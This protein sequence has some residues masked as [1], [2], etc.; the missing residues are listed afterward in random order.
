MIKMK[1]IPSNEQLL[2]IAENIESVMSD[3]KD[4]DMYVIFEVDKEILFKI[5]EDYFYKTNRE[6]NNFTPSDEVE[7]T[8]KGVKFKFIGKN[9]G[10]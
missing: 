4:I 6:S 10:R 2:S 1:N 9:N 5:D 3:V 8:I 7:V